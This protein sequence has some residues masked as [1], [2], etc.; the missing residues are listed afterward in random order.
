MR[1]TEADYQFWENRWPHGHVIGWE[2]AFV[3]ESVHLP[4]C[5]VTDGEK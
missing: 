2:H 4:D 1:A 5:I 3:H